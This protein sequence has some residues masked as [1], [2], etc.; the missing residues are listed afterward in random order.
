MSYDI[1]NRIFKNIYVIALENS[2]RIERIKERFKGLSYEIFYGVDGRKID[3]KYYR[4][5]GSR[6]TYGQLG[7][8]LSHVNLYKKIVEENID[9]ALILEDDCVFNEN[10]DKIEECFKNIPEK[11]EL[12]YLGYLP[13]CPFSHSIIHEQIYRINPNSPPIC[14]TQSIL[15]RKSFAKVAYDFNINGLYTADGALTELN[16]HISTNCYA[17]VPSMSSQE[18]LD[19]LAVEVDKEM[20]KLTRPYK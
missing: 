2:P 5:R 1:L 19:C 4:D 14:G 11:W 3:I 17:M 10:I 12:I 9:M 6:L 20:D 13:E 15:L 16:K 18:G 7:C 8:S